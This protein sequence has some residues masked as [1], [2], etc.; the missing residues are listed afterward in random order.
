MLAGF[1]W[2]NGKENGNFYLGFRDK[3][4]DGNFW[5]LARWVLQEWKRT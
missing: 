1:F 2:D 4:L 5:P 3:C